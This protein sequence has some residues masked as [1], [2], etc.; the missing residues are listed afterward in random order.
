VIR[1]TRFRFRAVG[2]VVLIFALYDI[3]P[4]QDKASPNP[5]SAAPLLIQRASANEVAA[6]QSPEPFRYLERLLWP[7][8]TETREVI[9][10]R[11][12]RVDRI[13]E[14]N[15]EP[16]APD[17]AE[18][19]QL[20]LRKLLDD[21][22]AARREIEDQNSET[23]RR[24]RMMKAFPAAFI[25]EPSGSDH[26]L[27]KFSFRP[28]RSFSPKD[29]ETQVYRGMQGTVW[30]DPKQERL[31]KIEG[32]LTRDVSFGWGIFGKLYKG[33]HYLLEQTEVEQRVW[34]ITTLDLELK[35][36]VFFNTSHLLRREHD[37]EFSPSP[38][39]LTYKQAVRML[40]KAD[41]GPE[42]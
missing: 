41:A 17:Q 22:K 1:V 39:D 8:G 4:A 16:V 38:P 21:S 37:R 26:G 19:Q 9:E 6:L 23:R 27:L 11:E 40:L 36:R 31:T 13:V 42:K 14:F 18:K 29:R 3:V 7:W 35:M 15:D 20:Q 12:G 24:I 33:G 10:T 32:T 30:V 2:A 28:N 34:R 5:D 25:F